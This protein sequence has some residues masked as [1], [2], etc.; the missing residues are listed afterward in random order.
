MPP[1]LEWEECHIALYLHRDSWRRGAAVVVEPESWTWKQE[2]WAA[3]DWESGRPDPPLYR[4][5]PAVVPVGSQ[6]Y[7]HDFVGSGG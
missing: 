7:L 3:P 2:A 5:E 1:S 4:E 6:N